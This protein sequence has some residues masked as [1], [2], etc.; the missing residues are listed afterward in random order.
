VLYG[1]GA[2]DMKGSLAAMIT[3]TEGFL[4]VPTRSTKAPSPS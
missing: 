1:R 3:A 4:D 2:C